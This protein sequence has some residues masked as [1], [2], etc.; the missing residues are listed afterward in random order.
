MSAAG[1]RSRLATWQDPNEAAA[2]G[3]TM[4]GLAYLTAIA[5]GRIAAPPI[6][7]LIGMAFETFSEGHA[8]FSLEPAECHYNPLG[9]VHGGIA[10]TLLDS[11][12]SCAVHTTIPQG[13][14][15]T[16]IDISIRFVRPLTASS[17]RLRAEGRVIHP[18][19]QVATA[20]GRLTD[21]A[22]R[23]CA[24]GTASC[25]IFEIR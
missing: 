24:H 10:A 8:A 3:K 11:A 16:T 22:G 12:M 25:L 7:G 21:A 5:E 18:G 6:A 14:F 17:G 19:R 13:R 2:L 1:E 9:S 4:S 23:L 15:Y 20:E